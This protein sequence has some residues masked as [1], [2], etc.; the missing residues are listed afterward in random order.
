MRYRYSRLVIS[1]KRRRNYINDFFWEQAKAWLA[2]LVGSEQTWEVSRTYFE[3]L[4]VNTLGADVVVAPV[5]QGHGVWEAG[6]L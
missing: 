6:Q 4:V 1:Y 5:D 2:L 3:G